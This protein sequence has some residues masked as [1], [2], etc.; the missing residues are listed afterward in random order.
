MNES[1]RFLLVV[2]QVKMHGFVSMSG[3]YP[4]ESSALKKNVD[5]H[6]SSDRRKINERRR[7]LQNTQKISAFTSQKSRYKY[8]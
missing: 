2:N 7:T 6:F 3:F 1:N 4:S 8:T 5:F